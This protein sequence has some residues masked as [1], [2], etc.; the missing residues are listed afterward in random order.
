[1]D[2][3]HL[4]A[5]SGKTYDQC[6]FKFLVEY[7]IGPDLRY[8]FKENYAASLGSHMH[9]VFEKIAKGEL[10]PDNWLT[11][12]K[13]RQPKLYELAKVKYPEC[14]C[15]ADQVHVDCLHLF[16]CLF[17]RDPIFNPLESGIKILGVEKRFKEKVGGVTI[18]GFMDLVLELDEDTIEV[19][20]YK[21]GT[22]TLSHDQACKDLQ[23]LMYYMAAKILWPQYKNVLVTLDYIQR[24]PVTVALGHFHE[25]K[26]VRKLKSLWRLI[27]TNK[28]P[29]RHKE[30]I[31]VCNS[32]C[33]REKCDRLWRGYV[34]GGKSVKALRRIIK[35]EIGGSKT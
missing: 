12:S 20:D 24:K 14:D 15:I 32:F 31:W 34:R 28:K 19:Y 23:V 10:T 1:M 2:I 26:A 17:G 11:W 35:A 9:E 27:K 13:A 5:S 16:N 30:P 3:E 22:W 6:E 29:K 7:G 8:S 18:K 33:D 25:K 4:S 21:T